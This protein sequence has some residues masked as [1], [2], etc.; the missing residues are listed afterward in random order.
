MN[1]FCVGVLVLVALC[2]RD[3]ANRVSGERYFCLFE[4]VLSRA[5]KTSRGGYKYSANQ[6]C[7]WVSNPYSDGIYFVGE[8]FGEGER[9]C[10]MAITSLV[11]VKGMPTACE[12]ISAE[13]PRWM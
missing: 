3:V 2:A 12:M 10:C 8:A 13:T 5:W 6:R 11:F 4:D 1:G 7:L 9:A